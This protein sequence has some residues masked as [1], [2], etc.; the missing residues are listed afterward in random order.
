M[1]ALLRTAVSLC[2]NQRGSM[3][4]ETALVV[5]VLVLMSVGSF[6]V[7]TMVSRQSEL[8]S[9]IAE[10]S[11]IALAAMPETQAERD[12]VKEVIVASTGL[13]AEDVVLTPAF[14]CNATNA[15]V[16]AAEACAGGA[17]I[18]SYLK[19]ELS[20]S[21]E[22]IWNDFGVGETI[23]YNVVRYVMLGQA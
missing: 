11:A 17:K 7:S 6:Q 3:A 5:P 18:S 21:Y 13:S 1:R 14:R 12:K 8:Q 20:A 15:Y 10:A 2:G 16:T 19:L 22:P 23:D 4:V 9:A